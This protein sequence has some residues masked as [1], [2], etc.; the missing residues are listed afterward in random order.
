MWGFIEK[1]CLPVSMY[2][3]VGCT[4][5]Q[6]ECYFCS[7][8][9]SCCTSVPA[10]LQMAPQCLLLNHLLML[11]LVTGQTDVLSGEKFLPCEALAAILARPSSPRNYSLHSRC[12]V[13]WWTLTVWQ[14]L[15][16]GYYVLSW[17]AA[18]G[19]GNV[20][21][22]GDVGKTAACAEL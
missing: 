7:S 10:S 11:S 16:R 20:L 13:V 21:S 8:L 22:P 3:H 19:L 1:W 5:M 17:Q 15:S 9:C 6:N 18:V 4:P 2:V 12:P 14:S